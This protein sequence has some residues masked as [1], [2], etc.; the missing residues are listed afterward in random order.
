MYEL[1]EQRVHEQTEALSAL[2]EDARLSHPRPSVPPST[3]SADSTPLQMRA[4]TADSPPT[5]H[6]S[7]STQAAD[8]S[9]RG[10]EGGDSVG[11]DCVGALREEVGRLRSEFVDMLKAAKDGQVR[12]HA[13]RALYAM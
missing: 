7:T 5:S 13:E 10:A 1:F 4:H 11:G 3:A 12:H 6:T 9:S 8:N 2:I